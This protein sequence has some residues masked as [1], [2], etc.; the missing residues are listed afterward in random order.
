MGPIEA[1]RL[2]DGHTRHSAPLG[3]QRVTRACQLLFLHEQS[4]PRSLP[5]LRRHDGRHVHRHAPLTL[6]IS[7]DDH[8][9]LGRRLTDRAWGATVSTSAPPERKANVMRLPVCIITTSRIPFALAVA[10]VLLVASP[11]DAHANFINF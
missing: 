1:V 5:L 9:G 2:L 8:S 11:A 7:S 4:L 6:W 3:G 10:A